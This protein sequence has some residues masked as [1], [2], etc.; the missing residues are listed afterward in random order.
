MQSIK[1]RAH[2]TVRLG[3]DFHSDMHGHALSILKPFKVENASIDWLDDQAGKGELLIPSS[4]TASWPNNS[5]HRLTI[6]TTA[7]NGDVEVWGTLEL[8]VIE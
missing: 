8:R 5:T 7:G 2:Q 3:L 4:E 6:A 1:I